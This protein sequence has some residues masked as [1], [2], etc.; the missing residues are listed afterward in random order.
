MLGGMP[1][2]MKEALAA[3]PVEVGFFSAVGV[4]FGAE[5]VEESIESF[6]RHG[7]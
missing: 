2:V 5:S 4:V 1:F 6:F 3:D 7:N